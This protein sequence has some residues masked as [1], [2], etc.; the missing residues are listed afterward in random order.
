MTAAAEIE[1]SKALQKIARFVD[2]ALEAVSGEHMGFCLVVFHGEKK[3]STGRNSY[4]SNCDREEVRSEL[5]R[6]LDYWDQEGPDVPL[7]EVQ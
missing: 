5:R 6:L 7:H 2:E 3:G 4:V 1:A